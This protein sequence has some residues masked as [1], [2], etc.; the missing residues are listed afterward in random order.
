MTAARRRIAILAA[1]VCLL[2]LAVATMQAQ[3]NPPR[4]IVD[5]RSPYVVA[6][7]K[8]NG[9]EWLYVTQIS[10]GNWHPVPGVQNGELFRA[11]LGPNNIRDH[12]VQLSWDAGYNGPQDVWWVQ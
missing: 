1:I 7:Q 2:G 5:N 4:L 11:L 10:P 9:Q 12:L 8:W 3:Q 6:V